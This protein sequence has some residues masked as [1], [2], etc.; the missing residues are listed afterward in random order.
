M[1]QCSERC[2]IMMKLLKC[3]CFDLRRWE[4]NSLTDDSKKKWAGFVISR[5]S[6]WDFIWIDFVL[7][8]YWNLLLIS[9]ISS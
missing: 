6:Y 4:C 7:S 8:I 3:Y 1:K 2:C 5:Q 9:A